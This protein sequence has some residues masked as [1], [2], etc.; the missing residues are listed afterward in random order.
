[1]RRW[2]K[3][4]LSSSPLPP[5]G[6]EMSFGLR[7]VDVAIHVYIHAEE[8]AHHPTASTNANIRVLR[9][10]ISVVQDACKHAGLFQNP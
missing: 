2:F 9:A 1:M 6:L 7:R 5:L 8:W 10:T 4:G 3:I